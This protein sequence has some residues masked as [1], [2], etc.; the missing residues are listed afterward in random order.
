MRYQLLV[1]SLVVFS[2]S[3]N[4]KSSSKIAENIN[5]ASFKKQKALSPAEV[6]DYYTTKI[7]SQNPALQDET[8]DRYTSEEL[9]KMG[10][11]QDPLLEISLACL[12]R[13]F[14]KAFNSA[15]KLY[16]RFQKV[17]SYWTQVANCHLGQANLRKAMLFYNKALEIDAGY[18]PA[19]NN[20]GVLYQKNGD[21]QKALVAFEKANKQSRF[22][23]TPRYNLGKLYL[24]YGLT[25]LSLPLL[26]GL[27]NESPE[28]VDLL[29]A[30][31]TAYFFASDYSS[32]LIYYQKIPQDY[33]RVA[34][35]GLNL[36]ATVKNL[37]KAQEA[38]KIFKEIKK[39]E[40]RMMNDY[41][42][43]IARQL[44]VDL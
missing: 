41:Y 37:G 1:L 25:D 6:K 20:L 16:D 7:K 43:D 22:S 29:N 27:L 5:T 38:V 35:V 30:V 39:P 21:D 15:S 18:V 34:E 28:D 36:S 26:K 13:D 44:G 19:L 33:W 14:T 2:C 12:K 32:A 9:S 4:Q 8:L 3:S 42:Q 24:K 23:K 31:A 40:S 11:S 10:E 17:P